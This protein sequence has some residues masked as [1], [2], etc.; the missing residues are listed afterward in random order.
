MATKS[1]RSRIVCTKAELDD[2]VRTHRV[3]NAG[4]RAMVDLYIS[5]KKGTYG[6]TA[7]EIARYLL[8]HSGTKGHDL[9]NPLTDRGGKDT[10]D[11]EGM[12][13][14]RRHRQEHG[15]LFPR[16]ERICEI[17]GRKVRAGSSAKKEKSRDTL[18]ISSIFWHFI[19]NQAIEYLRSNN[20]LMAAWREERGKW[21]RDKEKFFAENPGFREFVEGYLAA[22][23]AHAEKARQEFQTKAG[24]RAHARKRKKS[25]SGKRFSRWHLWCEW[26]CDHPEII[27][28]RGKAK[29][30][31]FAFLTAEEVRAIEEEFPKREDRR[32]G[33]MLDMLTRKNPELAEVEKLRKKY[34]NDYA[35]FR[36]P[37]TLTLP[38]AKKHPCW[39]RLEKGKLYRNED[40]EKGTIEILVI[41]HDEKE[42]A[43]YMD[44]RP[45]SIKPEPRLVPSHRARAFAAEGRYPPYKE[46]KVGNTLNRPAE[47]AEERLAGLKGAKLIL[48]PKG[49]AQLVF[50][51]VEQNEPLK[52]KFRKKAGATSS[53]DR[54]DILDGNKATR[55]MGIDLGARHVGAYVITEGKKKG[56]GWKLAPLRKGFIDSPD[57]PRLRSITRHENQLKKGRRKRG[58]PVKN[59]RSFISLQGH[60]T[61]MSTDRFK[62]A[63]NLIVEKARE[64]DVHIIVFE[65]LR[66]LKPTAYDERWL[67][68]QVRSMN[69]RHIFDLAKEMAPEFGI[70]VTDINPYNTSRLCSKCGFPGYRFS[71][72][73]KN[74]YREQAP[75][76][77]CADFGYPV[78]D[79]GGHLFRCPH[80]GYRV[81]AD[82]NAAGNIAR[83]FFGHFMDWECKEYTYRNAVQPSFDARKDFDQWA[84]G[85]LKRRTMPDAPF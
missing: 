9:M 14:V 48:K 31:G 19:C 77:E 52:A 51:V 78:W 81:Q 34:N 85:V 54:L 47:S 23:D 53:A 32:A 62:K 8:D 11:D 26:I 27:E 67:N 25:G 82:L 7:K 64:H 65:D 30:E 60:R 5:M 16:H 1:Y 6:E 33:R 63:A 37:P 13:L 18:T 74:P 84:S 75:R 49:N 35:R 42:D 61:K 83:K 70:Q 56:D 80:C 4:V 39:Y 73:R 68:R 79:S 66:R 20:E 45:F 36:R 17:D 43:Y 46:G 12:K 44:W 69:H 40:F 10:R 57:L 55:V 22:F 24:Q 15:I 72:K 71:M 59:E 76:R 29:G 3:F 58:K 28:W 50:T 41:C 2:L 21:L 38:S